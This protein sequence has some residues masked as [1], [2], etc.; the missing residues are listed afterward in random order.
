MSLYHLTAEH[1]AI[2][3]LFI[4]LVAQALFPRGRG[5]SSSQIQAGVELAIGVLTVGVLILA[6]GVIAVAM[7]SP[8]V[9][10]PAP[11]NAMTGG[12]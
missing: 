6:V 11:A 7:A 12:P 4:L 5:R 8:P 10:P 2:A 3:A 9:A 1:L